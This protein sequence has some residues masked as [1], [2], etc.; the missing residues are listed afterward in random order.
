MGPPGVIQSYEYTLGPAGDRERIAETDGTARTYRY[1][2]LYRLTRET[3][4]NTLGPVYEKSFV[5]DPVGNRLNQTTSGEGAA[6]VNYTYDDQDRLLT[7]NSTSNGWDDDGNLISKSGEATYFWDFENRLVRVEKTDGTVVTH[8]Y[9]ADGNRVRTEVT[10][11]TGPPQMTNFLVDTSGELSHVVAESDGGGNFLASYV[12]GDELLSLIRPG[13]QRFY[14][15]DGLGSIRFLSD[16][17]GTVTDRYTYTGFGETLDHMGTDSQPYQFAAEPFDQ[18]LGFSY[19]RA[20]WLDVTTGRFASLDPLSGFDR[21]PTT[22]H[23]YLYAEA[24]PQNGTDPSGLFFLAVSMSAVSVQTKITTISVPNYVVAFEYVTLEAANASTFGWGAT[25]LLAAALGAVAQIRGHGRKS[26]EDEDKEHRGRIQI[27]GRDLAGIAEP[28][29]APDTPKVL[30][31]SW[32]LP[33]PLPADVA[34][35]EVNRR[36]LLLS[37]QQLARRAQA[38]EKLFRFISNAQE[39]GGSGPTTRSF[40]NSKLEPKFDDARVD[41]QVFAG[42]AFYP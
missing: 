4:T 34:V 1:D 10:P 16:E 26:D 32:D 40:R 3:I 23:G 30:Q 25:I 19:N 6:V 13:E 11:P 31:F 9:D 17:D 22:L 42:I 33:F 24:S 39:N 37:K 29:E 14:H 7:E 18:N 20:R 35:E 12:R 28:G 8:A 36:K 21:E 15:D 41:L 2:D 38:F 5:Y 27:Q